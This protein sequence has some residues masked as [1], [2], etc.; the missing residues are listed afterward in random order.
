MKVASGKVVGGKVL[1]EDASLTEGASVAVLVREN[2]ET[3]EV[4]SEEEAALLRA[5]ADADRGDFVSAEQVI[6]E[7]RSRPLVR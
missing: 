4:N 3:F 6:E 7:L 2:D 5:V 1:V